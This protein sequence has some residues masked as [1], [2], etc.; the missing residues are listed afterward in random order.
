MTSKLNDKIEALQNDLEQAEYDMA[1][2]SA[3]E[4]DGASIAVEWREIGGVRVGLDAGG[5]AMR[6]EFRQD[7]YGWRME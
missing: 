3:V 6:V 1:N 2:V 4:L 5:D 7:A